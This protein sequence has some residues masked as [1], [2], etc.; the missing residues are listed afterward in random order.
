MRTTALDPDRAGRRLLLAWMALLAAFWPVWRWYAARLADGADDKW[1]LFALALALALAWARRRV[2][3]VPDLRLATLLCVYSLGFASLPPLGRAMLAVLALGSLLA[4]SCR[5]PH[6]ALVGLLLLSLPLE[7]TLQYLLG[8]PLRF[9]VATSSALLLAPWGVQAQGTTLLW[10]GETVLVDAPCSGLRML[11]VSLLLGLGLAAWKR[12]GSRRTVFV[13]ATAV[14]AA[15]SANVLRSTALF[16]TETGLLA[17]PEWTHAGVG[18][19]AMATVTGLVVMASGRGQTRPLRSAP[20]ICGGPRRGLLLTAA[21]VAT[22]VPLLPARRPPPR[23]DTFPGWPQRIEDRQLV[24]RPL[25]PRAEDWARDFPGRL[26]TF[27]SEGREVLLRWLPRATRRLHPSADCY[28]GLGYRLS[29]L[30]ARR[31]PGGVVWGCSLARREEETLRV[32]EHLVDARG[33]TFSDVSSW[34][35]SALLGR[36]PGPYW[37]VTVAEP[38]SPLSVAEL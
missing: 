35:W 6:A 9:A 3:P 24:E 18:L 15:F 5:G 17:W 7:A 25:E 28:R 21:A 16:F 13:A 38:L 4:R 2:G 1:G 34:Y 31:G 10:A 37:A 11:W 26:A 32:C 14:V 23:L 30:P 8:Y 22:L 29:P 36:S 20:V 33:R 19:A 27:S 12:L